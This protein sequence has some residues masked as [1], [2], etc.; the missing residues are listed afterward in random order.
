MPAYISIQFSYLYT[1][2]VRL[3]KETQTLAHTHF[4]FTTNVI[5]EFFEL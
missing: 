3:F 1:I 5:F 2:L 4:I